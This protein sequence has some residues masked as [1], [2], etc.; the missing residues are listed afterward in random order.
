M[1][2]LALVQVVKRSLHKA[3]YEDKAASC[4]GILQRSYAHAHVLFVQV[5]AAGHAS[6]KPASQPVR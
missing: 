2:S 6:S 3:L 5:P 1:L 4:L